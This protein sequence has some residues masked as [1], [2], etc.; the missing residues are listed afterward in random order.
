[1]KQTPYVGR[2][3]PSPTGPLHF[4]SLVAALASYL[5]ARNAGGI[6]RV[7]MEDVDGPRC[8]PEHARAL[9]QSLTAFGLAWDGE[10]ATQSGRTALYGCA[11]D[12]LRARGCLYG[13]ACSRREV[14]DS[15]LDGI[16]GP[17]YPGTCR[18]RRLPWEG[19]AVRVAT[20]GAMIEFQD[21]CQGV[22]RQ[23][24]ER[25]IG[26]FVVRRRDGLFSYQLAVVVDDADQGVTDVV[27][28]ADLLDSSQRQ[29]HLQ[30][31][32]GYQTPRYLHV[33]VATN[34]AGQKLSKQTLAPEVN[35]REAIRW[36]NLALAFLGQPVSSA[37]TPQ[38]LLAA[39]AQAWNPARIPAVR[40][41][42]APLPALA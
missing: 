11:L 6:W 7:R 40:A 28:G 8:R 27:R 14:S 41:L 39:A 10:V 34:A 35:P 24:L 9:L 18:D 31:L 36:L 13:C 4:G 21:R 5:D 3:A 29:I 1:M 2:F 25:D 17:V 22:Q 33:P 32:L 26:D 19:N 20:R 38:A 23:A 16:E 42:P 37:S 15:A 12:A 30:Q